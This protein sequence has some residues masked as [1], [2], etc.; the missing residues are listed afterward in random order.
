MR[1]ILNLKKF[2]NTFVEKSHFKMESIHTVLKLVTPSCWMGS[3]DLKD[4]YSDPS[5][6]SL[7]VHGHVKPHGPASKDTISRWCKNVPRS[8]GID[9]MMCLSL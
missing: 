5:G 9:V 8:V 6:F 7:Q 3:L 2:N 1:L 4:A